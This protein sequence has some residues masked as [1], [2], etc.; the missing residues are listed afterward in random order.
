MT[1]II[2]SGLYVSACGLWEVQVL[3]KAI[4]IHLFRENLK[5]G[6]ISKMFQEKFGKSGRHS[7]QILK[8]CV[9]KCVSFRGVIE[10]MNHLD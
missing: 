5:E 2:M 4:K 3:Q 6:K 7:G 10:E 9:K 1:N 8:M